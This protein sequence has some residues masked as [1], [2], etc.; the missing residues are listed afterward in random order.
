MSDS[1]LVENLLRKN[2]CK[3]RNVGCKF[4]DG[5]FPCATFAPK[6]DFMQQANTLFRNFVPMKISHLIFGSLLLALVAC[7]PSQREAKQLLRQAES[8]LETHPDSALHLIDS[9][10]HEEIYFT[11]AQRMEMALLQARA[12]YGDDRDAT[13]YTNERGNFVWSVLLSRVYTH[14]D[15][16]RAAAYFAQKGQFKKAALAALYKGYDF[17]EV[18]AD[19][20]ALPMFKEAARYG[21]RANDSLTVARALFQTGRLLYQRRFY[22][23]AATA[24]DSAD[25]YFGN[26]LYERAF[27]QNMMG[28][29][30]C[31]LE[32]F[33]DA[34]IH[35]A[36][37]IDF[38]LESGNEDAQWR[39]MFNQGILAGGK[40]FD[41]RDAGLQYLWL[42]EV[43]TT[44]LKLAHQA[45][46]IYHLYKKHNLRHKIEPITNKTIDHYL[47]LWGSAKSSNSYSEYHI[48][49][50]S[51]YK[52]YGRQ[53]DLYPVYT[54]P[55]EK[56]TKDGT[57]Y[58]LK[59]M[60]RQRQRDEYQSIRNVLD[61]KKMQEQH[62]ALVFCIVTILALL[63]IICAML[64]W[65]KRMP[66]VE[67]P[68]TETKAEN[69]IVPVEKETQTSESN[70]FVSQ[71]VT[72]R[73]RLILNAAR[74]E[75]RAND[76]KKE[77]S[78]LV[79]QVMN[80]K[81]T[82][83]EAAVSVIESAYPGLQAKISE[84]YP[85]LNETDSKVCLLSCSDITNA[86]MGEFLDLSVYS[87]NKSRSELRKKLG[88]E[89]DELKDKL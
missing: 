6:F 30:Q 68:V 64:F 22:L 54:Q 33:S 81:E 75:K 3:N 62:K 83:F 51:L 78:P 39:A 16:D 44:G 82:A 29:N 13:D 20:L 27:V 73:L 80:G 45:Y 35:F 87:I 34:A 66:N 8:V 7:N 37:S 57:I 69:E 71:E 65:L 46:A 9:V 41:V 76:F 59:K 56:S 12:I 47:E 86:E 26:R 60:L 70:P 61:A 67:E 14:P 55:W 43:D 10:M 88:F 48:F 31:F 2:V 15:L 4:A 84:L 79:R 11:E 21:L 5:L 42:L 18:F 36:N 74:T 40:Y 19:T 25:R 23:S 77:W 63:L 1:Q 17:Q 28:V 32:E 85:D 24:L 53:H 72:S 52:S 50:S 89:P 58:T 49:G 38:A